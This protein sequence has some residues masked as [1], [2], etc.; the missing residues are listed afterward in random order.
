VLHIY[1]KKHN[2]KDAHKHVNIPYKPAGFTHI[3]TKLGV[4]GQQS[5]IGFSL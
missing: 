5:Q 2:H 1:K 3:S 4:S